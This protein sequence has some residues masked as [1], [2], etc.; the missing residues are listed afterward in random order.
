MTNDV[1]TILR[2]YAPTDAK[3]QWN[4][5]GLPAERTIYAA[6]PLAADRR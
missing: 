3:P 6:P 1:D 5:D 2:C 4:A